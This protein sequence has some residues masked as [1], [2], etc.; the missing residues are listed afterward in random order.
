MQSDTGHSLPLDLS[1]GAFL[2]GFARGGTTWARQVIGAHPDVFD[3][4]E[5]VTFVPAR[6]RAVSA[7]LVAERIGNRL[8]DVPNALHGLSQMKR[9]I[10]KSPPNSEVM[11]DM[12]A[13]VP[14][15]KFIYIVRDPRDVL[16]SHQRTGVAW[17]DVLRDFDLAMN[18]TARFY[19]GFLKARGSGEVFCFRYEDLH[20]RFPDTFA[21]ICDFLGLRHDTKLSHRVMR[22]TS[23]AS[24]TGRNHEEATG[25]HAR[26]GVIRDWANHLTYSDATAFRGDPLWTE[27]MAEHGYDWR[28]VSI[29]SLLGDA[30]SAGVPA[31]KGTGPGIR[32]IY[33]L[34]KNLWEQRTEFVGRLAYALEVA[35]RNGVLP[36]IAIG[37]EIPAAAVVGL[38]E[39]LAGRRI[40]LE[41][42]V[43]GG[44]EHHD[45][46]VNGAAGLVQSAQART[47]ETFATLGIAP[48]DVVINARKNADEAQAAKAAESLGLTP[49]TGRA[50]AMA[51]PSAVLRV[52]DSTLAVAGF[53]QSFDPEESQAWKEA[54]AKCVTVYADPLRMSVDT[55]LALGF[56]TEFDDLRNAD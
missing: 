37:H 15:G 42:E 31:G 28:T 3:I 43:P 51:H 35:E 39:M 27:M 34:G 1:K 23:F 4:T 26:R 56:R 30:R 25:K 29:A 11:S 44:S 38:R 17:T 24:A 46:P 54:A 45:V 49:V 36:I 2:C 18:R 10:T 14:G 5:P 20:Q 22:E 12:M 50:Y 55:P 9:F 16:I 6:A 8:R 13:A 19:R 47:A 41:V 48:T 52:A 32:L 7:E 40:A 33:S 53:T 21:H